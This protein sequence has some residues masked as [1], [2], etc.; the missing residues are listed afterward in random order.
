MN[1]YNWPEIVEFISLLA[2][3]L[4]IATSV[5]SGQVIFAA[6]P[7][8]LLILLNILNRKRMEQRLKKRLSATLDRLNKQVAQ[9]IE[10]LPLKVTTNLT[11][12]PASGEETSQVRLQQMQKS[13]ALLQ[14]QLKSVSQLANLDM[15]P[16][17][18]EIAKQKNFL[19]S[20]QDRYRSLEKSLSGVIDYLNK[21]SLPTRVDNLEKALAHTT[22]ELA[23]IHSQVEMAMESR[24]AEIDLH[25]QALDTESAALAKLTEAISG[26]QKRLAEIDRYL[27]EPD[28]T[29]ITRPEPAAIPPNLPPALA[30]ASVNPVRGD[31]IYTLKAQTDWVHALAID[32]GGAILASGSFDKTVRLWDTSGKQISVLF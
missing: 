2:T 26:L 27:G 23:R 10:S 30:I 11:L 16:L 12:P 20:V 19:I 18:E 22:T 6:I 4:G 21:S 25:L 13:I 31:C 29:A 32:P 8:S 17:C 9:Q 5:A 24:L 3:A 15:Q 28:A 1:R 7:I 14:N